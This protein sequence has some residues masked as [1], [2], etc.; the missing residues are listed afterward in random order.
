M[1]L[2]MCPLC[3][4]SMQA[5]HVRRSRHQ[6]S[7]SQAAMKLLLQLLVSVLAAHESCVQAGLSQS[8]LLFYNNVLALPV[9]TSF[10]LTTTNEIRDVAHYPQI[11]DSSFQVCANP[12][13]FRTAEA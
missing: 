8:A 13:L 6:N 1:P 11:H 7:H 3:S 10:M 2:H 12:A 5:Y 9:M 4:S